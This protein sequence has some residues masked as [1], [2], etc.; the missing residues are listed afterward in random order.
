[1]R[2]GMCKVNDDYFALNFLFVYKYCKKKIK[3]NAKIYEQY[4]E[5]TN[6]YMYVHEFYFTRLH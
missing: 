1:M 5:P 3:I 2:Q 6:V 4:A